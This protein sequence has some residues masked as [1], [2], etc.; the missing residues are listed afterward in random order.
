MLSAAAQQYSS[1]GKETAP[2]CTSVKQIQTCALKV[3]STEPS[4]HRE[5]GLG[6]GSCCFFLAHVV[7]IAI[8][9]FAANRWCGVVVTSSY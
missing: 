6:R 4:G 5:A 8:I 1:T 2:Y 9:G 3:G 7:P